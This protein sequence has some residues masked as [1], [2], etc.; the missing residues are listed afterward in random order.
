[1]LRGCHFEIPP[2]YLIGYHQPDVKRDNNFLQHTY[3]L[4]SSWRGYQVVFTSKDANVSFALQNKAI[5]AERRGSQ[6]VSLICEIV[7]RDLFCGKNPI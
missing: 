2:F 3:N 5:K 6:I 7:A 4:E 1:M